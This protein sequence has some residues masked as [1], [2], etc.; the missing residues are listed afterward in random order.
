MED[1]SQYNS[2]NLHSDIS[3]IFY[4]SPRILSRQLMRL[5]V[6]SSKGSNEISVRNI[7]YYFTFGNQHIL[8]FFLLL[9]PVFFQ[10]CLLGR[11]HHRNLVNL[12]GYCVDKG[13]HM[14][15]YEFMSNGS[16]A[17]ILY[18]KLRNHFLFASLI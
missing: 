11:L 5:Q 12:V 4:Y 14:L 7:L 10:V 15:I 1:Y 16:L 2:C 9:N 18:S 13:K 8:L 17:N 3:F 6:H